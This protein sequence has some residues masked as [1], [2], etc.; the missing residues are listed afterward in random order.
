MTQTRS[1]LS[2][3]PAFSVIFTALVLSRLQ[4]IAAPP[5]IC[6]I[7]SSPGLTVPVH[8]HSIDLTHQACLPYC[9]WPGD[10]NRPS[11]YYPLLNL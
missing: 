1:F 4:A 3:R 11:M 7:S 8:L 10:I 2:T 5:V 6:N 9:F